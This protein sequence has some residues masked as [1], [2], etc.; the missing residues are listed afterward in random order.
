MKGYEMRTKVKVG[1]MI[2][3]VV[4][5]AA[6]IVLAPV[7]RDLPWLKWTLYVCAALMLSPLFM[8]GLVDVPATTPEDPTFEKNRI[9]DARQDVWGFN[10][11]DS[12]ND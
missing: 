10:G 8:G 1:L 4:L 3:G 5:V 9:G 11:Q 7:L 12:N 6:A 2:G